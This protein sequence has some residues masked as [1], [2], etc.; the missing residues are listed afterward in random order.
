MIQVERPCN[1]EIKYTRI[2]SRTVLMMVHLPLTEAILVSAS[3]WKKLKSYTQVVLAM[4]VDNLL[5][6]KKKIVIYVLTTQYSMIF[7]AI[8][9]NKRLIKASSL[10]M[11]VSRTKA[12][13]PKLEV[14]QY[15]LISLILWIRLPP[16]VPNKSKRKYI[17][18]DYVSKSLK[19]NL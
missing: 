16:I 19:R 3:K 6:Q 8:K 13:N 4:K 18:K 7:R 17:F 10:L 11:K 15:K 9:K 14:I 5:K 12:Y 2:F 1:S